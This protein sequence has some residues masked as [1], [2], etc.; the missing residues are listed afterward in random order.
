MAGDFWR[1]RVRWIGQFLA[2]LYQG[3]SFAGRVWQEVD[4]FISRLRLI[5]Y[6]AAGDRGGDLPV[7][8]LA[9]TVELLFRKLN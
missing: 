1:D 3:Q 6:H 2:F 9:D 7:S 8:R 5:V 4:R